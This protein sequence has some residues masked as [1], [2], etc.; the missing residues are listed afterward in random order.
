MSCICGKKR[1]CRGRCTCPLGGLT[2]RGIFPTSEPFPGGQIGSPGFVGYRIDYPAAGT[3]N[4]NGILT[5][6]ILTNDE[7]TINSVTDNILTPVTCPFSLPYILE[8]NN[9][10]VCTY[11]A[12]VDSQT[13]TLGINKAT[14]NDLISKN[15]SY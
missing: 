3:Y 12:N 4:I 13:A 11:T 10:L 9:T 8:P 2:E 7:I 1:C 15:Q 5:I 6:T 14:V